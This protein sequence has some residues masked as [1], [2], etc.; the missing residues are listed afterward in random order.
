V[1]TGITD[2]V[3][4]WGADRAV[5]HFDIRAAVDQRARDINIVAA[6]GP[7]KRCLITRMSGVRVGSRRNQYLHNLPTIREIARPVGGDMQRC[8]GLERSPE[9]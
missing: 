1:P 7:M 9:W 5:R 3:V 8:P 2:G 4:E 6:R